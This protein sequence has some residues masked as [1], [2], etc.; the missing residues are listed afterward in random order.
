M[1]C[2]VPS[3]SRPLVDFDDCGRQMHELAAELFPICRSITGDGVRQ[4]LHILQEHVPLTIHEVPS[5]TRAF[6]WIVPPEWN[7]RDA[8]ILDESGERIL[9][10]RQNN[11]HVVGYSTPVDVTLPLSELQKHLHSLEA[12]PT[13]IPYVTS[14]YR[15]RWGFCLS[16]EQRLGL[17]EGTYHA[18]ID[19]TLAPGRSPTANS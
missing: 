5:G 17:Q 1:A 13:A 3:D 14:Y 2:A 8:Y 9:D 11:L 7:I 6:D 16:H 19:A 10:F 15:E 4:T 18:V 12:Q